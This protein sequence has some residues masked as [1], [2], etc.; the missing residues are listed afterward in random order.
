MAAAKQD[1]FW[2][3]HDEL[4]ARQQAWASLPPPAAQDA[5]AQ[6]A[7][8]I[9][10]DVARW[11]ADLAKPELTAAIQADVQK[12]TELGLAGTPS[13]FIDGQRYD[14]RFDFASL[15]AAILTPS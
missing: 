6:I 3:F 5:F 14:G 8:D 2:Q 10:L 12:A 9:G 4:F 1:R 7:A 13:I 15:S 11:Q